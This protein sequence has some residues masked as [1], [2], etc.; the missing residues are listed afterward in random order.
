MAKGVE[1]QQQRTQETL[2]VISV[3]DVNGHIE[4][5]TTLDTKKFTFPQYISAFSAWGYDEV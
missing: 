2:E 3:K 5:Y 4:M 1:G